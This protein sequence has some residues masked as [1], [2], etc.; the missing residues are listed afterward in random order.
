MTWKHELGA[1]AFLVV[2]LTIAAL[3]GW[4]FHQRTLR[5]EAEAKLVMVDLELAGAKAALLVKPKDVAPVGTP[6]E[7]KAAIKKGLV[8]PI[9]GVTLHATSNVV[10]IP[11]P[12]PVRF[13]DE[14]LTN[15]TALKADIDPHSG[16]NEPKKDSTTVTST[17]PVSFDLTGH[18]FIGQVKQGQALR[19]GDLSGTVHSGDFE[20]PIEFD[21]EHLDVTVKVSDEIGKA[22]TYYERGWWKKHTALACPGVSLTYNPMN[23]RSVDIA[24]TCGYSFVW[25]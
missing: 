10:N 21:P 20:A 17:A 5:Q 14:S 16:S 9:A 3:G 25:F 7:V 24:L 6:T 15:G 1:G 13:A 11:C 19:T 22:V 23:D 4:G 2:S 18:L 12:E 8:T